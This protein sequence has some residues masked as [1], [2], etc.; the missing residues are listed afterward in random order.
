M[1]DDKHFFLREP[2]IYDK[3]VSRPIRDDAAGGFETRS[4]HAGFNPMQNQNDFR[5]FVPPLVQSI[6]FP[7]E[8]F[9]KIPCPVYGRTRTPTN[10]VLEERIASLE[11]GESCLTAASGSQALFNLIFTIARPGDNVVTSLNVF[12][13]GYKQ[14]VT[15]FPER[16]NVQFR[17]VKDPADAASWDER[18]DE[19]T[20]L[21][22]V[23]TPSNP[24]LF[25]TDIQAVADVA[26][27]KG[28]PLMVDNTTATAALQRPMDLGADMV[29]LSISKFMAGNA[30][31]LG[32][33]LV[34]P[35]P[36]VEDIRWNTTEFIGAI[37]QPMEA[38]MTLQY[39]E[40]LS[41]RMQRHSANALAV[42]RYLKAHPKVER[43]N[44]SGLEDHPQHALACRQMSG[45]GGLLSFVAPGGMQGA[46]TVMN[47]FKRV[48]HAVTFGTSRSI[49]MHPPTITHEHLTPDER[50]AAGI[51]DG[52]I[53]FSVG[54]ENPED[55]ITDLEQALAKV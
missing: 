11:G 26:H 52:L 5:S 21:V 45:H 18:I 32:G 20:K 35:E 46:A 17:F 55:I 47:S 38:W 41:M 40:T 23:E 22:W 27:A 29:M 13:E 34:G 31:I 6:T 54:L 51:D 49:C 37:M 1:S 30:T 2:W 14:A 12:G 39:V 43:V 9:D 24:C 28:V 33:A 3:K 25:V 42:A 44:Y 15:I 36:L 4:L 48:V 19:K 16:C 8:T 53:R 10:T 50:K 7:Y